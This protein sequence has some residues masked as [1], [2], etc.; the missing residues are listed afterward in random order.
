MRSWRLFA[1]LALAAC[2][3]EERAA[4]WTFVHAAIIQPSCTT[5]A[6]HS[7]QTAIAGVNLASREGAYTILT[8][9]I[10]GEEPSGVEPPNNYVKPYDAA[11]S[12]LYHMLVGDNT[13]QMPPDTPLPAVEVELVARWIEAG[14]P[15]D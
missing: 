3:N 15:C 12:R 6:C 13:D 1:V 11:S 9:R 14:A 2:A 10:C 4:Q 7:A 5:S 8:G